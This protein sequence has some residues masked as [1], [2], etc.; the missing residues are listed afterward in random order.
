VRWIVLIADVFH[1]LQRKQHSPRIHIDIDD[2]EGGYTG[3]LEAL[4]DTGAEATIIG[5]AHLQQLGMHPDNLDVGDDLRVVNADGASMKCI[6]TLHIFIRLGDK[7]VCETVYVCDG[8]Q[9]PCL[10]FNL[11]N[12]SAW[13][14]CGG[15]FDEVGYMK[16]Q[17]VQHCTVS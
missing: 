5:P 2:L 1:T 3:T 13:C 15:P 10:A 9:I 17:S 16:T 4:P 8:V 11:L 14:N 6:G 12:D 7:C